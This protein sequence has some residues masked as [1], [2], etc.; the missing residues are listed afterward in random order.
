MDISKCSGEGCGKKDS[1]LRYLAPSGERQAFFIEPP[2][3]KDGKCEYFWDIIKTNNQ[4][5]SK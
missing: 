5:K 1:C 3:D 4:T 2:L